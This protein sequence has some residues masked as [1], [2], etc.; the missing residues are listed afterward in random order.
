MAG[1]L[2][3]NTRHKITH[4]DIAKAI[5]DQSPLPVDGRYHFKAGTFKVSC[6]ATVEA[7]NAL[8]ER[9]I[10]GAYT[11]T[12]AA[13]RVYN[14]HH[15]YCPTT[16]KEFALEGE[17]DNAVEYLKAFNKPVIFNKDCLLVDISNAKIL[18]WPELVIA[19]PASNNELGDWGVYAPCGNRLN[20]GTS[21]KLAI[22]EAIKLLTVER[23]QAI[24]RTAINTHIKKLAA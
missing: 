16:A 6:P 10:K 19:K 5:Q 15:T 22:D 1:V 11:G 24:L 17:I 21:K 7:K 14:T 3:M 2:I 20:G 23:N 9:L 8:I 4:K 13:P 18:G 12:F